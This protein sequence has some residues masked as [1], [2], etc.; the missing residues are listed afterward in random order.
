[1]EGIVP[2]NEYVIKIASRCNLDCDYCYE[3]NLGDDSWKS[4]PKLMAEKTVKKLA[5]RIREHSITHGVKEVFL[6]LHG[7]EPLMV[8]ARK[9]DRICE[10]F[11][12]ELAD[13][14]H[15]IITTQT[16]GILLKEDIIDVVLKHNIWVSVSLDGIKEI[17]DA[18]R[19][20]H[21]NEGSYDRVIKGINLL[22]KLA[23]QNFAGLL[24]VIDPKAD[25][26]AT[27]DAIAQLEVEWVDFLLPHHN[28]D[29]LP[30]RT[31]SDINYEYG[32]WYWEIFKIWVADK[33]PKLSIR[34][35]E[36][37]VSQLVGGKNTFE[38]MTLS[39]CSLITIATDGG[40]EGVDCLKSTA[41]GVQKLGIGVDFGSFDLAIKNNLV[42]IRQSGE[43]Q[44]ASS[45]LS[46]S[47]KKVCAGGYFPHRWGNEHGFNNRSVYCE[48]LYWLIAQIRSY[49][50]NS[51]GGQN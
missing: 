35:L 45:C 42:Q 43:L 23:P 4:Q 30:F 32:L 50:L 46:C 1:M 9:L 27:L 38:A 18:H 47:Y 20:D 22:K 25:P 8:G 6:S 11:K 5:Q 29:N 12:E 39:P 33:Y 48:D 34:F 24:C 3:Y 13:D 21:K 41:S 49:L 37:I 19:T 15:P 40:Y 44:L 2:L 31:R 51:R 10:I 36:N 26:V 16:N 17:H 7:G 14:V 28:W